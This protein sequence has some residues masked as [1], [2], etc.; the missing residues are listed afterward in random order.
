MVVLDDVMTMEEKQ[1]NKTLYRLL[2]LVAK[3]IPMLLAFLHFVNILFGYFNIDSTILTY[4]GGIS[5]LPILF[6][7][8]TSYALKFCAYHRMFIH[9]C[10]ITNIINIYDEYVGI[11]INNERYVMLLLILT[12]IMLFI[13]LYL[14]LKR[15]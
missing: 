2:L 11:N 14:K 12:I 15:I 10:V 6:L 13:T 5:F 9:Y 4:L 3:V 8:I 7:Y 1:V